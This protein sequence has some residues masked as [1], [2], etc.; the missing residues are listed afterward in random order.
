MIAKAR[1]KITE[2]SND[3]TNFACRVGDSSNLEDFPDQCFDTVV[4][5]FGLCSYDDPIVVLTEMKRV[6]K[7]DGKILL[8]EHGRSKTN[9]FITKYLDKNSERHAKNW[10][11]YG[12]IHAILRLSINFRNFVEFHSSLRLHIIRPSLTYPTELSHNSTILCL[13]LKHFSRRPRQDYRRIGSRDGYLT[14][15]AFRYDVLC[16]VSSQ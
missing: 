3:E 1:K 7:P 5:T 10:G 9:S 13:T 6:C 4:D 11:E 14:Y 2:F 16:S 12:Y 15:L 8:L